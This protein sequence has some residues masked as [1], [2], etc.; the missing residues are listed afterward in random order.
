MKAW[1]WRALPLILVLLYILSPFDVVPDFLLGPGWIDDLLLIGVLIWFLTA[2]RPGESPAEFYRR[3]RG[4][5]RP[6]S[7]QGERGYEKERVREA[8][9]KYEEEDPFKVLGVKPGASRDEIKAARRRAVAKYHP[10]KVTHLGKEFQ[11]MAH[12]KLLAIQRAY[13][14]LMKK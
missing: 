1:L 9:G 4:Y 12:K 6:S 7:G 14:T 13:E 11:E 2:R 10:D 3:Y 8:S 5:Q